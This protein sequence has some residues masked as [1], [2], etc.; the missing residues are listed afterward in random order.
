MFSVFS[1]RNTQK[2][3]C[4]SLVV[5]QHYASLGIG[6]GTD[7]NEVIFFIKDYKSRTKTAQTS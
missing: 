7:F 5:L 3:Q 2:F 4:L 1:F 6:S